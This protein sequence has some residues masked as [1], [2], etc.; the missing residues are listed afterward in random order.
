MCL[1]YFGKLVQ[2]TFISGNFLESAFPFLWIDPG[3]QRSPWDNGGIRFPLN[4]RMRFLVEYGITNHIPIPILVCSK[5]GNHG[6]VA[7]HPPHPRFRLK[8]PAI[9][10]G[11]MLGFR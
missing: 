1:V 10:T 11:F 4:P 7:S 8:I 6:D 9:E 3:I 2:E 5:H